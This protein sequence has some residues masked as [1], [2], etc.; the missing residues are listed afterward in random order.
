MK[1]AIPFLMLAFLVSACNNPKETNVNDEKMDETDNPLFTE[2]TLPYYAPDF[3][4][5]RNEHFKPAMEQGIN[6]KNERIQEIANNDEEPT[7]QNTIVALE[8]SGDLLTRTSRVFYALSSSHTNDTIQAVSEEMAPKLSELNDN[9]YLND[10]LFQKIKTLYENRDNL[11]FDAE[12]KRLLEKYYEDFVIAGANLSDEEKATLKEYNARLAVL[13]TQFGRTLLEANNAGAVVFTDKSELAGIDENRLKSLENEDGEGWKVPLLNTTQQPLLPSMDNRDSREKLF[14]SAWNRA[15]GANS[16]EAIVKEIVELR[17]KKAQLLGFENYA[18]WSLQQTMAKNPENVRDFFAQLVPAATR[19]AK[20]EA[21]EIQKMIRSKGEDF[22]V[23]P[24]DWNY[25]GEMV[26]KEKYD[27]D[28][29][30]IKP[31]FELNK[32]LHDGV[33]Y[34]ATKLY[35]ITFKERTDIPVY[36]ED[37]N[38]YEVFEENGEPLGL[39]YTDFFARSSKRGGA[40]MS[41]FVTQSHLYGTKPVIYN[42]C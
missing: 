16:T 6:E 20:A 39:F 37:V 35:G 8:Q 10:Q 12:S 41:N 24:W 13:T 33:F 11:D 9:I 23:E 3:S 17:A 34:A 27:L 31:Y 32:V 26:R 1:K 7:F 15:T 40:W 36:H 18:A 28:E 2:S 19:L 4:K 42:V 30:Q 38:V 5:I 14:M 21:E 25:Y 29:N 22:T